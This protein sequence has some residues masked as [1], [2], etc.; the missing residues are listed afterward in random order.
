MITTAFYWIVNMSIGAS[1]MGCMVMLFGMIKKIPRTV[2][3]FLWFL[4]FLRMILPVLPVLRPEILRFYRIIPVEIPKIPDAF[5]MSNV[6][7]L[8]DDYKGMVYKNAMIEAIF[9]ALAVIWLVIAVLLIVYF[10]CTYIVSLYSFNGAARIRGN[11][12]VSE[13]ADTAMVVGMLFPR[14][15]L[16]KGIT[17][18]ELRYVAAH[19]RIHIRRGD[20]IVRFF[21]VFIACIHWFNPLSW[22]FLRMLLTDCELACDIGALYELGDGERKNYARILLK[23]A[24]Q[25]STV[26][27]SGFG[28]KTVEARIKNV[29]FYKKMSIFSLIFTCFFV[30]IFVFLAFSH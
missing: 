3:Y 14:V 15:I 16:P 19:E 23:F 6:I 17:A 27:S 9:S 26:F 22:I 10:L 1:I 12:F 29:I 2:T 5:A 21:A 7:L 30:L 13:K 20:N 18:K 8:I 28:G 24:Q 4:P 11:V 25:K